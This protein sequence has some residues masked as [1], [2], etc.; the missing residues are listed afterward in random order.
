MT[1][2]IRESFDTK[3]AGIR[4]NRD[5]IRAFITMEPHRATIN[6]REMGKNMKKAFTLMVAMAFASVSGLAVAQAAPAQSLVPSV[7]APAVAKPQAKAKA[8]KA[9]AKSGKKTKAR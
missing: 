8:K 9:K 7:Q 5:N 2:R 4:V 6:F 3:I 1:K